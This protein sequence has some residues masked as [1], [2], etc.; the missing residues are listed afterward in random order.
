[1]VAQQADPRP[2]DHQVQAFA[3]VRPVADN[4]A[5]AENFFHAL[6]AHVGEH[7]LERF[8]VAVNIA[9]DGPFQ[10]TA[11]FGASGIGIATA[12]IVTP[13]FRRISW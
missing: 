3:R 7:R 11:R 4:V 10:F 12:G 1:M 2:L 13:H 5:Q 8:Q 6:L 9:D